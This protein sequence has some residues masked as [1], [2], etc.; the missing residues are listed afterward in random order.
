MHFHFFFVSQEV[1][2]VFTCLKCSS[3]KRD[4]LFLP[5]GHVTMC[6]ECASGATVCQICKGDI[7]ERTK[8]SSILGNQTENLIV[9]YRE[10]SV[11]SWNW[12]A[13][14]FLAW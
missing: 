3:E 5:C 14:E 4:C 2:D 1:A 10:L 9:L 13:S 12:I 7:T 11:F 6:W 8:V